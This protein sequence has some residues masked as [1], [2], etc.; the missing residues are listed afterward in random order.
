VQ[1]GRG[2]KVPSKCFESEK[3]YNKAMGHVNKNK[4][5]SSKKSVREK[6]RVKQNNCDDDFFKAP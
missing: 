4:Q 2:N 6:F 3:Y 5:Q 1:G